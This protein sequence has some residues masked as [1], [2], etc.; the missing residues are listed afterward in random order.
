MLGA[1]LYILLPKGAMASAR[2]SEECSK[3]APVL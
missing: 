3:F 2:S 1:E